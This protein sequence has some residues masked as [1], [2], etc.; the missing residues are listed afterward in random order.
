MQK[1]EPLPVP[2]IVTLLRASNRQKHDLMAAL[3]KFKSKVN[4]M[5]ERTAQVGHLSA[6]EED[7]HC[8]Y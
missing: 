1:S 5:K 8:L 6:E 7:F 3:Q 2:P 4:I